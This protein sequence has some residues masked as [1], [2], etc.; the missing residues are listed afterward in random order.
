MKKKIQ[1]ARTF[2]IQPRLTAVSTTQ[3]RESSNNLMMHLKLP[4]EKNKPNLKL[5]GG[6]K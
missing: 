3:K 4:E 1:L 6:R 2:E 5:V